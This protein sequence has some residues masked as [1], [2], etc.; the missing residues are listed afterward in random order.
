MALVRTGR[1]SYPSGTAHGTTPFS[2][3]S[4]TPSDNSLLVVPVMHF[5]TFGGGTQDPGQP[6][7]TDSSSGGPLSWTHR[8]RVFINTDAPFNLSI[9]TAPVTT[10]ASM[11]I[12]V[13]DDDNDSV[14]SWNVH[15]V[16]FT[17]YDTDT[18][19]GGFIT[20]GNNTNINDGAHT[21]TLTQAPTVDD[22]TLACLALDVT[23]SPADATSATLTLL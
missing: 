16:E 20:S 23:S 18:P 19:I 1:G 5:L 12:T 8:G 21:L 10:G 4:F 22:Q 2:T 13:D 14:G 3:G 9:F 6:T 7:I 15:V 17:G 11:T